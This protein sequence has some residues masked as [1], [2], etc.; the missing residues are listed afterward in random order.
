[1]VDIKGVCLSQ[2][3]CVCLGG[4]YWEL[5]ESDGLR[6]EASAQPGSSILYVAVCLCRR[7]KGQTVHERSE[8]IP[9]Q[10]RWPWSSSA[11]IKSPEWREDEVPVI[12]SAVL[13]T[14]GRDFSHP[15]QEVRALLVSLVSLGCI[16]RS[17]VLLTDSAVMLS[18]WLLMSALI[19]HPRT[20]CW[21]IW[22]C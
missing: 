3:M 9:R 6:D 22:I 15:F 14:L 10:R 13:A 17:S 4:G 8:W 7:A 18:M 5:R 16:T 1:M 20:C 11:C 19:L 2:W 12:F 21:W